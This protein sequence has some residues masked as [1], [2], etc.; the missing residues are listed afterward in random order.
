[1]GLAG[2]MSF[3]QGD[4]VKVIFPRIDASRGPKRRYAVVLSSDAYNDENDHGVM[5]A[6]SSGV[7]P[8]ALPGVHLIQDWKRLNL[9]TQSVVVPWLWTLDWGV[10]I[11]KVSHMSPYELKQVAE[12]LREVI[13]I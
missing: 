6:I 12:R 13:A 2:V 11:D 4:L 9:D 10:V 7:P 1:M 8:G 3:S 5:V